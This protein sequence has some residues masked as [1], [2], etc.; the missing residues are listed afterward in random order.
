M[1]QEFVYGLVTHDGEQVLFLYQLGVCLTEKE[2]EER[3]KDK[4][5][6][7]KD[8]FDAYWIEDIKVL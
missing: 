2:A 3:F 6:D 5:N 4:L 1:K 7:G 8:G